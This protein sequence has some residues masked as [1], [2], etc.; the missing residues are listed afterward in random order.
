M[1][2]LNTFLSDNGMV[3]VLVAAG[4]PMCPGCGKQMSK[5]DD[6]EIIYKENIEY[7]CQHLDGN[8]YSK[9]STQNVIWHHNT[10]AIADYA[11]RTDHCGKYV[12]CQN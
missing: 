6:P 8:R 7:Y 4:V 12:R 3:S 9:L 11:H 5:R 10:K 2:E 1:S